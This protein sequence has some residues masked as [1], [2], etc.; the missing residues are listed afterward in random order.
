MPGILP[1]DFYRR[2]PPKAGMKKHGFSFS[3]AGA[4]AREEEIG[5]REEGI[6]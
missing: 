1:S 6:F 2:Q 5:R 4:K 3:G